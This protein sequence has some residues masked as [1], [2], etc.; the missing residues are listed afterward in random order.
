MFRAQAVLLAAEMR[1]D[2]QVMLKLLRDQV[3]GLMPHQLITAIT[4]FLESS[5]DLLKRDDA[6]EARPPI[7]VDASQAENVQVILQNMGVKGGDLV[8][9]PDVADML[10]QIPEESE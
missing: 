4:K 10:D 7:T 1:D 3:G 8:L 9:D 2:A 6:P 5:G